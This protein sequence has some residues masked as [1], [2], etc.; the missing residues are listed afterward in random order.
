MVERVSAP[1][2]APLGKPV[3]ELSPLPSGTRLGELAELLASLPRLSEREAE[4]FAEDLAS[5]RADLRAAP[6]VDPW[7]S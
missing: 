5:A 1:A 4:A 2:A 3:A 7:E 6:P